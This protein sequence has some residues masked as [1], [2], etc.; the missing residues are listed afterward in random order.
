MKKFIDHSNRGLVS[1][2]IILG[3]CFIVGLIYGAS[4]FREGYDT[5]AGAAFIGFFSGII[6][7]WLS[8][9]GDILIMRAYRAWLG[10]IDRQLDMNG[11]RL[12]EL[13]PCTVARTEKNTQRRPVVAHL[14]GGSL[15]FTP[16]VLSATVF[17]LLVS[18]LWAQLDRLGTQTL[19]TLL[20][21]SVAATAVIGGQCL[22][23]AYLHWRVTS[24][25]R[26][27]EQVA[28]RNQ[29]PEQVTAPEASRI[30]IFVDGITRATRVGDFL[31]GGGAVPR[32]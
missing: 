12:R 7:A 27:I 29:T 14:V 9:D 1:R 11:A 30:D 31:K 26:Q 3:A 20:V 17:W 15:A 13:R 32:S 19:I 18:I 8:L 16:A 25:G 2:K 23:L 28:A 4:F 21:C 22:Y 24:L 5:I 10:I 6:S